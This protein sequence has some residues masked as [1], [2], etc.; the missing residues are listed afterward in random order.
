MRNKA[1][2]LVFSVTII[3]GGIFTVLNIHSSWN[4]ISEKSIFDMPK[5]IDSAANESIPKR[6]SIINTNGLF[7]KAIGRQEIDDNEANVYK[8]K[9]GQLIYG[10]NIIDDSEIS[11]YAD[12]LEKF[13][14]AL[15]KDKI[16]LYYVQL[17][18][19][20]ENGS[21]QMPI[22][23]TEWANNNANRLIDK[24]L[25]SK[26]NYLDLRSQGSD[27]VAFVSAF[28]DQFKEYKDLF[29][30]TDQHWTNETA[31]WG[32][33]QILEKMGVKTTLL[34]NNKFKLERYDDKFLG[35]F[36]KK[37][38]SSYGGIDD[39]DLITPKY[40][41]KFEYTI[42]SRDG[43]KVKSGNFEEA[44]LDKKNLTGNP[45]EVNTY[46]TYTGGNYAYTITKNKKL[47]SKKYPKVLLI[48]DSF[49]CAMMP[50]LSLGCS[51]VT[52]IDLRYLKSQ[53]A[54]EIAKDGDFDAVV[55]A[56]N[57]SMFGLNTF[58]FM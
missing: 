19:K 27:A 58:K 8:M 10:A 28:D 46:E 13:N 1:I 43:D 7:Q 3:F 42:K 54:L 23:T 2:A 22:G 40:E 9:N 50:F 32:A 37:T 44:L 31:L 34:E 55:V 56:Y 15:N 45:Y 48:R 53:T 52:A 30:N 35:S 24:L 57:P 29:Y 12:S 4:S 51:E 49:S 36:G 11:S 38:G 21:N 17:P 18:Y 39:Y 14:K 47:S 25:I 26:I 6:Y 5:T 16:K 41:T 20:I 33:K